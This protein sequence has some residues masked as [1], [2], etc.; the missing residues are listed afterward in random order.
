MAQAAAGEKAQLFEPRLE[1]T[2]ASLSSGLKAETGQELPPC[3]I[4]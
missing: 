2:G 3:P 4:K 1:K